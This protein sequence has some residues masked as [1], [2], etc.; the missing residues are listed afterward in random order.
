[1]Y[2]DMDMLPTSNL[3]ELIRSS[4]E[5]VADD[6]AARSDV[7][8]FESK[9]PV[10]GFASTRLT[11]SLMVATR[12][13]AAFFEVA[14]DYLSEVYAT[15]WFSWIEYYHVLTVTG[16]RFLTLALMRF[17]ADNGCDAA[18]VRVWSKEVVRHHVTHLQGSSWQSSRLS[19]VV[20]KVG[21]F[22]DWLSRRYEFGKHA[23]SAQPGVPV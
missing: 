19:R 13:R 7:V 1:M 22:V 10:H 6:G 11:N 9:T 12:P 4:F 16:S 17:G 2:A 5:K 23:Q 15:T 3:V 8:L 18:H 20:R 14:V 21:H